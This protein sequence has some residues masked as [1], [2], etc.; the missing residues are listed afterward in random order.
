M[1]YRTIFEAYS[2]KM[3]QIYLYQRAMQELA[4]K[5]LQK[6]YEYEESLK[7]KPEILEMSWSHHNMFFRSA[8]D[9]S[10]QFFGSKKSA[11]EDRRL[12]VVLHKNKQ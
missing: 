9:G 10:H 12:S 4:K 3:T 2:T 5:E 11:I 6:L 8:R 7:D 1:E